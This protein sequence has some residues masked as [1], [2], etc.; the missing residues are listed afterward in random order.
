MSLPEKISSSHSSQNQSTRFPYPSGNL[1]D[2]FPSAS[3][4]SDIKLY[5]SLVKQDNTTEDVVRIGAMIQ[6]SIHRDLKKKL[7]GNFSPAHHT[8]NWKTSLLYNTSRLLAHLFSTTIQPARITPTPVSPR[9][10]NLQRGNPLSS[11]KKSSPSQTSTVS[12]PTS[13]VSIAKKGKSHLHRVHKTSDRRVSRKK[14]A[15]EEANGASIQKYDLTDKNI[16]DRLQLSAEEVASCQ[17]SVNNL[18]KAISRYGGLRDKNSRTGQSLLVDQS[19]FLEEIQ[20]KLTL[21]EGHS[22]AQVMAMIKSEYKSHRVE[23]EKFIHGIWVAGAPPDGTDAYIKTFLQTYDDFLFHFWV[24]EKAYGAAKFTSSIKKI[25]F[26]SAITK[27]RE[28]VPEADQAFIKK[29][30]ELRKKYGSTKNPRLQNQYLEDMRSMREAYVALQKNVRDAFNALLLQETVVLQDSFFN[31]CN[32]RGIDSIS[33]QTRIEYLKHELGFSDE[34]I[35]D[36]KKLIENNKKKIKDIV[37]NVN[38]DLGSTKVIIRDISELKSMKDKTNLHNYDTEMFLRWNYAAA[39]DQVR[40]YMLLEHGGIYAD[41]DM[42][43]AYS[44]EVTKMIYDVGGDAFFENLQIRRAISDVV[45]KLVT[46]SSARSQSISLGEIAQDVDMSKI[47]S[48]DKTKLSQLIDQLQT[49]SQSHDNKAFFARMASDTIRDFMPIL[50]RYHK[51]GKKWNV[52]GLNGLMMSHK[53][54]AVVEAVIK[55]Q[56]Q[57]YEELKA[58]RENVLSGVFFN[59]LQELSEL[60]RMSEVGGALVKDYLENSLFYD[61][62]QDSIVP[63]AVSTL[64]ITGPDLIVNEMKKYFREQGPIGQDFL[65]HQGKRLG[66]EAFLG[67]YNRL[68]GETVRFDWL[69]PV[70]VGANDVTPADDSTWCG[71]KNRDASDLLF[72]DPSKLSNKPVKGISRSTI[73]VGTFTQL[74]SDNAKAVCPEELLKRFNKVISQMLLDVGEISELDHDLSVVLQ[75]LSSDPVARES[76]FSLQLQL[77]ELLRSVKFPIS[78][79]VNFFPNGHSN[80]EKDLGKAIKLYLD[81]DPQT[82]V[83]LWESPLID[84]VLFLKDM[85]AISERL[86]SIANFLDSVDQV[87]PSY[88]EIN[89]LTQYGELKAKESLNLLSPS[90]FEQF[91]EVTTKIAENDRLQTKILEIEHLVTSGYLYRHYEQLLSSFLSLSEKDFKS[92]MLSFAKKT[93]EDNSLGKS[94]QKARCNWYA[95]ICEKIYA[96]RVTEASSRIREFMKKFEGNERVV[97]LN[98]DRHLSGHP[99]FERIQKEGYAFQDFQSVVRLILASSGVSG[100]L[101]AESAFPAPSKRLIDTMKS[102]LHDD[103]DETYRALPLVYELLSVDKN[104]RE[105]KQVQERM[106]QEGFA[107]LGEKLSSFSTP[108]LLTPPTDSSVTALGFRYGIDYGRESEQTILN[109]APGIFNPSGYTM[110]LYLQALYDIHREIH[111]GSLTKEKA[112]SILQSKRADCFINDQGIEALLRY[113]DSKYYCSLTEVHRILTGQFFLA[114]ASK[115]LISGALPGISRIINSDKNLGRPLLTTIDS[116]SMVN[117]YDYRGRG[118]SKDLLSAPRDIP[119]IRSIVEGA[120]YTSSSWS[121][122]FN[123]H[124]EGWSDLANRLGGKSVDIHP[125]TFLYSAEGRCMGL[126]MLYMSASDIASYSLIQGNL[127]TVSSLY[128]EQEREGLPLTPT[129]R[130][131]LDRCQALVDWLQLQGNKYLNSPDVFSLASWSLSTLREKF[132]DTSLKSVLITTPAH[133]L[134]LQKLGEGVYR[135]TDP[136][137]GH[138]DFPS[139]DQAFYFLSEIVDESYTIKQRYGFSDYAH[140]HEQIKI[141]I[142][143]SKLFENTLFLG[144]DLGLTSQHQSTTLEKMSARGSVMISQIPV[145]WR[146]LYQIG[147]TVDHQRISETT[148]ESDLSRLKID[149]NVLNNYLSKNVL[150]SNTAALLQTLLKT[151]GLEPGTKG[152]QGRAITDA[153]NE[154]AS[155]IQTSKNSMVRIQSSLQVMIKTIAKKLKSISITDNDQ[156]KIKK[157]DIDDADNLTIEIESSDKRSKTITF[158]GK[159]LAHSF[160]RVGRMLN[161]L[162]GTGVLDLDLGMSIV[163]LIQYARMVEQGHSSDEL[164]KFNLFMDVKAMS[165]LTLG[166]VIQAMG[167]KFIVESGVNTFRLESAVA[168]KLQTVAQKVGGS[169]GRA[170][171]NAAKVLELPILETVAGVWNLYNSVSILTQEGSSFEHAAARVQVAFDTISL[172]LTLSSVAAPSLMLAAGPIAAIGMGAT[173]IARNVAYHESRHEAW[174][175]YK[176]FLEQGSKNVVVS[177]PDQGILDLSGNQVLGNVYLDLRTNPPILT[178]DPSYNANRWIGHHRELTDR[179]VRD[180]L[181]YA[182][183]I[184]P[185]RALAKGHANSYWP[186][187]TPSIPEGTYTTVIVG[188]GIQYKAVTEV[189]Y[190]SNQVA[191]REAVMESNSRY[192][193]PPLTPISAQTKIIGGNTPLTVLPVRLLDEGSENNLE[194]RLE[195]AKSYKDYKIIVEG[196]IGGLVVQIGGAGFYDLTG[197][198]RANNVISVFSRIN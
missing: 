27:L 155:L 104:S 109:L 55:A 149:G 43:P 181:S 106:K 166:S 122:F 82:K 25:A 94:D 198:P 194:A 142:P 99:L 42:M 75:N 120:K 74:W 96:Q 191:W 80:F 49:F 156:A 180:K 12:F 30:D 31:F 173:S 19:R 9:S 83:V 117:P 85:L 110:E 171:A 189:I 2:A 72:S 112:Q 63:G 50:Q 73:D 54:S 121:E 159:G 150:D 167:K 93:V 193:Q 126:S 13:S 92:E 61:F 163:S 103:H 107:E 138:V 101:S 14:R 140:V 67:A 11:I 139:V 108:N 160:K 20:E 58:L 133:S 91:L 76:I 29:Y 57:K 196:G 161:E 53:G 147:G 151:H 124:A 35:E 177:L 195:Q 144:S 115:Y 148:K 129:D 48:E 114:E 56:K 8:G 131:L 23:V 24:D 182:Y 90:E 33:D 128:Q 6:D 15:V 1:Q 47:S 71:I 84:R 185:D 187:Q 154:V 162:S 21:P 111:S 136:N 176:D 135:F 34:E 44:Q 134:T 4:N 183:S 125:Q 87:S 197:D 192:Y 16:M 130:Q 153:P 89:L 174:L 100:I 98:T 40:M 60:D 179:Q 116:S 39:T 170:L 169:A 132:K 36:Y 172:A 26:D 141:Y 81:T 97:L 37:D 175:K 152:I 5:N 118:L 146:T 143:N 22:S 164:A 157:V 45:L 188:Y 95:D 3:N 38:R 77:A 68:P 186:R 102:V 137:F 127:M 86:L 145:P 51:W 158:D 165:E 79:Q 123:T 52:R 70:T 190:L 18:K 32:M 17:K 105:A 7:G 41:L 66:K 59:G 78:N 65:E 10:E 62:R 168:S 184:S 46:K 113:S 88:S 64:G 178:G 69:H 28:S 119:S